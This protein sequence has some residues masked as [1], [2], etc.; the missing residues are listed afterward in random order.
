MNLIDIIP[1]YLNSIQYILLGSGL[2]GLCLFIKQ[3]Y[4][5]LKKTSS[6]GKTLL[7]TMFA[8]MFA[9]G[10]YSSSVFLMAIFIASKECCQL[11]KIKNDINNSS[12]L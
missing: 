4:K 9:S 2:I 3:M 6:L 7:L 1:D 10:I 11:K 8:Q 12:Y 5:I